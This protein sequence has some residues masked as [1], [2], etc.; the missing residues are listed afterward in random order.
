MNTLGYLGLG[1]MGQ[2]M[3]F[4]LLKTGLPLSVYARDP[5]RVRQALLGGSAYSRIL[6]VHGQRMLDDDFQ[7]GF[8]ARLHQ[9]DL[10]IVLAE[11]QR[12]GMALPVSALAAQCI[13]A[14]VGGGA[15]ELDSAALIRIIETQC[16]S[17]TE[18]AT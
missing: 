17:T 8:K 13:D 11:T 3:A 18:P 15:G 14:L 12:L 9:K 5:A 6:E 1:T 4:N 10:G 7:P 16:G 2:P